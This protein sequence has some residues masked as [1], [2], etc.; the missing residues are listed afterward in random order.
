MDFDCQ[1]VHMLGMGQTRP[2]RVQRK[3][4]PPFQGLP[5][6]LLR[7]FRCRLELCR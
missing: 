4:E 1:C 5:Y 3:L 7:G 2:T 6:V